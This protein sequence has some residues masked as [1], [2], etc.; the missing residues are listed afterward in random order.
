MK[1][2]SIFLLIIALLASCTQKI[3]LKLDESQSRLVV[4]ATITPSANNIKLT[5]TSQYFYNEPSPRVVNASVS[6]S[7]GSSTYPCAET[8]PGL[9]GVYM[10]DSSFIPVA[11]R[12]YTLSVQLIE[13]VSGK[14]S[15]YSVYTMADVVKLDS[16]TTSFTPALQG[17]DTWQIFAYAQD[18]PA[19][20]NCYLFQYYRND[21]LISDSIFKYSIQDD[22]YFNGNYVKGAPVFFIDN[23]HAWETLH[24]GDK[25]S[26]KMSGI[27]REYYN[28]ISQVQQS[29]FNIPFFSGPP[30]NVKG[31]IDNGAVG[32]FAVYNSSWA[33]T[34]VK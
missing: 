18:P 34:V 31:N 29:G 20:G 10:P 21:T 17:I 28:F 13:P 23:S 1:K 6:I 3:D 15:F 22:K 32:F 12:S 19:E 7:D 30:S 16:I 8:K 5:R 4:D 24:P 33:T 11:G 14:S 25:V 2:N 27:S 9:S 26:V